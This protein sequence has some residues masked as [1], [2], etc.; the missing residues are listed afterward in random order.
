MKLSR[1]AQKPS[2]GTANVITY[3]YDATFHR[4]EK[5]RVTTLG[6]GVDDSVQSIRITYDSLGRRSTVTSYTDNACTATNE[7]NE[8]VY[9]YNDFGAVDKEYQEHE[10]AKGANTLY[11]QYDYDAASKGWRL[12]STRY[13]NAR[14]VYYTYETTGDVNVADK[15]SRLA[16][17][18]AVASGEGTTFASYSYNGVGRMVRE[19]FE[20]PGVRLD[21]GRT[22]SRSPWKNARSS[23]LQHILNNRLNQLT[24]LHRGGLAGDKD[25][26]YAGRRL[27][28]SPGELVAF[29]AARRYHYADF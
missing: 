14:L 2:G 21:Y 1:T 5:Q 26:V 15:L 19:D 13:P 8:V 7:L 10:G 12:K 28:E 29:P 11:A 3:D 25:S 9:E 20:E 22:A 18:R 17:I 16:A 23:I 6:T 4:L 27:A 24:T